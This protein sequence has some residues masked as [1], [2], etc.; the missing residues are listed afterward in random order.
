M[1]ARGG[2]ESQPAA[3]HV[4]ALKMALGKD[5]RLFGLTSTKG[6]G[7]GKTF[8]DTQERSFESSL[9][10]I[11]SEISAI[12]ACAKAII[13]FFLRNSRPSTGAAGGH[14]GALLPVVAP[15]RQCFDVPIGG[16]D[17]PRPLLE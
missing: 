11:E 13:A 9:R 2:G 4:A 17:A 3:S 15:A 14:R 1:H 16:P 12:S 6:C 8:C 7:P 10:V 5:V